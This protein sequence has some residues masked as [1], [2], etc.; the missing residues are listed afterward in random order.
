MTPVVLSPSTQEEV[1]YVVAHYRAG[2][3]LE[4][5]AA[6]GGPVALGAFESCFSIRL[7]CLMDRPP[8]EGADGRRLDAL[9]GYCGVMRF[10]H[11]APLSYRRVLC[12]MSCENANRAKVTFVRYS[13]ATLAAIARACPPWVTEFHSAP[14]AEY[15]GS[16]IWHERVLRMHRL[17]ELPFRGRTL[18]HY[19]ILRKE[20][21]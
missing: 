21:T 3:R 6:G 16:L 15:R 18:I 9:V 10:P 2:E 1:D 14:D 7:S 8:P 19:A 12:F 4:H 17:G 13:R 5:E 20:L 11:D